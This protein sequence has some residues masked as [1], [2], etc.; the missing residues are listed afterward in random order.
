MSEQGCACPARTD[1]LRMVKAVRPTRNKNGPSPSAHFE[2]MLRAEIS[3]ISPV[4]DSVMRLVKKMGYAPGKEF[5]IEFALREALANA[6]LHGCKADP[7]KKIKCSVTTDKKRGILIVIRD[8]GAGFDPQKLPCP[9][10][11]QNLF[12]E[13]GRGVFLINQLMDEVRYERN[14]SEIHMRKY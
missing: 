2:V 10:D 14:G 4:V 3:A 12:S 8:P 11:K 1:R 13:H 7:N 5:H 9:T 6:I